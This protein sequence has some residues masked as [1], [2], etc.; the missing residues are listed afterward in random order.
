MYIYIYMCIY[1][2]IYTYVCLGVPAR[3]RVSSFRRQAADSQRACEHTA[4]FC[5]DV[6]R[7][8]TFTIM[9]IYIYI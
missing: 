2:Y 6:G 9:C 1:I 5:F 8:Y 7:I 3:C 4:D